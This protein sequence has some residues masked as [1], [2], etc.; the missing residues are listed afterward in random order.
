[1][2]IYSL[3]HELSPILPVI[4]AC[5]HSL[6]HQNFSISQTSQLK[7]SM[8]AC[9]GG[10]RMFIRQNRGRRIAM[11]LS[12]SNIISRFSGFL[13]LVRADAG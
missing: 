8:H 7:C 3:G 12:S 1:M 4:L 13:R 2:L 6:N 10:Y 5:A 9:T 11:G